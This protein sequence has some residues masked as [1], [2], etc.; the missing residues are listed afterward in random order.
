MQ[1]HASSRPKL[2]LAA[3][4]FFFISFQSMAQVPDST[5]RKPELPT[6]PPVPV[7][8]P[9]QP[10]PKQRVEEQPKP[11]PVVVASQEEEK[12]QEEQELRFID[13]LYVGGSFGLQFGT[14]TNISLLPTVSYAITPKLFGGLGVVYHYE[15]GE[16]FK[17]NHYGG[18]A[19]TQLEMFDIGDGAVLAHAEVE[20]LSI[21]V[22]YYDALGRRQTDRNAL[23]IPLIGVG[24]RQRISNKG[25]FDILVLYNGNDD[26]INPYSNPVIRVGF[27]IP[28]T[29]R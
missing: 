18:R 25:S 17:L 7:E 16:G 5:Y 20:S 28:L 23:T 4:F 26:L 21:E 3:L 13:K 22:P 27:N 24:Y 19:F 15:S 8:Q 1:T 11:A 14:Y 10:R 12:Q 6:G 29:P 2:L 9:Q